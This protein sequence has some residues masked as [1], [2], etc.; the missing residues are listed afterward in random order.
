M[1]ADVLLAMATFAFVAASTPGPNNIMLLASGVNFGFSRTLPHMFGILFGFAVLMSAVGIGLGVLFK[2]FPALHT[3]LKFAGAGYLVWLA[4]RIATS[5]SMGS[6]TSKGRPMSMLEA[7]LFQWVNPKGWTM[8]IT[9][10][11]VYT[12]VD[13]P[14]AS[15]AIIVAVFSAITLPSVMMWTAFGTGLRGILSDP[16]RLKWFNIAMGAA[17]VASVV[18]M[19]V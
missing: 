14:L 17:L 18:P 15:A 5:R 8:A 9:A 2:T 16:V 3:V 7:A 6:A 1:T 10:M 19:L 11:A 4:W 12:Q 13:K